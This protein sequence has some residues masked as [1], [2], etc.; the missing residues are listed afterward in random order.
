MKC[1]LISHLIRRVIE[2]FVDSK[3]EQNVSKF[4]SAL[5]CNLHW[6]DC[7]TF[8]SDYI[9]GLF[10]IVLEMDF[11]VWIIMGNYDNYYSLCLQS[12]SLNNRIYYI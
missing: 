9:I 5:S 2:P 12:K 4:L 11:G 8:Y 10:F 3:A 7:K 6:K 1:H